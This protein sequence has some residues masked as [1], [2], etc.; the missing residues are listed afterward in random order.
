[1]PADDSAEERDV[2]ASRPLGGGRSLV[3]HPR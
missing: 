1:M 3:G 2:Q